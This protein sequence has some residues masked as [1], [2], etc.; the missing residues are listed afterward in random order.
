MSGWL[1]SA[2]SLVS[3]L[4]SG[5]VPQLVAFDEMQ[6]MLTALLAEGGYSF[7]YTGVEVSSQ[8][9]KFAVKKVLAQD[10]ETREIAEMEARLLTQLNGPGGASG[11]SDAGGDATSTHSSPSSFVRCFGV[12]SRP[13]AKGGVEHYMLLEYCPN[14]SL[15]DLIYMKRP[16]APGGAAGGAAG[17]FEYERGPP[18]PQER[19]LCVFEEVVRAVAHMHG[20]SPPVAHRDL[21]LEN[22]LCRSDG[23]FALCD[24]GSATCRVLPAERTRREALEEGERIERY[25]T[26]MYRAPEMCDLHRN[27][28]VGVKADVWALG[29]IL[30]ALCFRDHPFATDSTLSILN[31][32]FSIPS[33]S[34][35]S[36]NVHDLIRMAL[37]VEPQE[38]ASAAQLLARTEALTARYAKK[39]AV[40]QPSPPHLLRPA[41]T[42]C[43]NLTTMGGTGAKMIPSDSGHP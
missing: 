42:R 40:P 17:G 9:T 18:L 15:I 39:P 13:A 37:V 25:S 34:P 10:D 33:G 30:Y 5:F 26:L 7:I 4:R 1:S 36:E 12:T 14:G 28:E 6:V 16:A 11:R 19:V 43:R 21:K 38:R 22:V 24:F 29:C 41:F 27:L 20:L 35:Y 2:S 23:S 3:S 8:A 32:A 31:G